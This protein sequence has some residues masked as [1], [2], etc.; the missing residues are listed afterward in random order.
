MMSY[1]MVPILEEKAGKEWSFICYVLTTQL[2]RRKKCGSF[3][4]S[5]IF[6]Q[7]SSGNFFEK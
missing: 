3:F 7:L 4:S 2:Y 6:A 5:I 1:N